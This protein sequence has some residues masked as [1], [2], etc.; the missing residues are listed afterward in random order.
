MNIQESLAALVVLCC[1]TFSVDAQDAPQ[2]DIEATRMEMLDRWGVDGLSKPADVDVLAEQVLNLPLADQSDDDLRKLAEQANTAANF[3]GFILD[4]YQEYYR[5]NY[6]YEFVQ[7]KVAPFHDAYVELS[8][9]LKGYRN[10]AYFNLG[11]KAAQR[12][13]E[14]MAFLFFRDAFRLS[15]FA[16]VE[17]DHKGMRFRAELELK[18]LLGIQDIGTF[19]FWS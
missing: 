9:R 15:S 2:E 12:G 18:E 6:R 5:D 8:N 13:D 16:E 7:E 19:L 3:V 11:K 1:L 17:G 14:V 4:E 10:Q